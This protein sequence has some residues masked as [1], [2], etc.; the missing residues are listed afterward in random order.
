MTKGVQLQEDS[1]VG[2]DIRT[3]LPSWVLPAVG[4]PD[5]KI[6]RYGDTEGEAG[7][8]C[9]TWDCPSITSSILFPSLSISPSKCVLN[10]MCQITVK[11]H[12]PCIKFGAAENHGPSSCTQH[13]LLCALLHCYKIVCVFKKNSLSFKKNNR[14]KN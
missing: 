6:N 9:M 11:E 10:C 8:L 3:F 7:G 4:F 5:Q 1:H 2:I 14:K 12:N 13:R